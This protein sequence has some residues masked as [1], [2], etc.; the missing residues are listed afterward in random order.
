MLMWFV[1]ISLIPVF[2]ILGKLLSEM[3]FVVIH[4]NGVW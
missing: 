2:V 1:V 4:D 3:Y